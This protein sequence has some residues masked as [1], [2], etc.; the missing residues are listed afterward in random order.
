MGG[1]GGLKDRNKARKPGE[2]T[3]NECLAEWN[4]IQARKEAQMQKQ[5]ERLDAIRQSFTGNKITQAVD[6]VQKFLD[7]SMQKINS[8]PAIIKAPLNFI[9]K[10]IVTPIVNLIAKI[11]TAIKNIQTFFDNTRMFINSV[12][13]KLS[14]FLGEMKNSIKDKISTTYKKA[15]KTVLSFF[16]SEEDEE[17]EEAKKIKERELKKILKSIFRIKKHKAEEENG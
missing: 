5:I 14:S 17:G 10:N 12:A 2:M 9:V 8:M 7:M 15:I 4:K 13:E 11:P 6:K 1:G 16:V 3:Y